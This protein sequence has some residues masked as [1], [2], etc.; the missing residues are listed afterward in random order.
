MN[1]DNS[2]IFSNGWPHAYQNS[3]RAA[4]TDGNLTRSLRNREKEKKIK[5]L[6]LSKVS[7]GTIHEVA[8]IDLRETLKSAVRLTYPEKHYI[9]IPRRF[10]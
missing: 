1:Y 7:W 6:E 8:F 2:F 5:Q 10:R 4:T 9:S 3:T